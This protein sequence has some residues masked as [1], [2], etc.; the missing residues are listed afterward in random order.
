[1]I[2][3]RDHLPKDIMRLIADAEELTVENKGLKLVLALSYGGR[4]EITD[5]VRKIARSVKLGLLDPQAVNEDMFEAYLDTAN[6][7]DPDLLIRTSGE[8][9]ISNFML[10]QLAYSELY[11]CDKYWPDFNEQDLDDA[12]AIYQGRERRYG[13]TMRQT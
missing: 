13:A 1:M 12:I 4:Q 7:P 6:I 2:G 5:A 11:F 10:W 8:Q 3:N 9:R